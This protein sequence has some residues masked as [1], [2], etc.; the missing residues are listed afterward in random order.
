MKTPLPQQNHSGGSQLG[1]A[2]KGFHR[3]VARRA[4]RPKQGTS[5]RT[6]SRRP[7]LPTRTPQARQPIGAGAD[8]LCLPERPVDIKEMC[9]KVKAAH[10]ARKV[11]IV[12]ASEAVDIPGE[13]KEESLDEFGHMILKD[14][15][16]AERLAKIIETE[17]KIETRTAVIGHMQRGG[18]P[19]MFDRILGT[20]VGVKAAD[21]VHEGKFGNMVAL[22]GDAVIAVSL[23]AATAKLKTV[24]PEW[25]KFSDD[26]L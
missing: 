13:K 21:L 10:A 9:A 3:E 23:E 24:T 19:T 18:P 12:V 2:E 6:T 11:A 1:R 4:G 7:W 16:V 15:G 20:R 25:L 8:Y 17:T 22:K 26:L 5:I 14:R